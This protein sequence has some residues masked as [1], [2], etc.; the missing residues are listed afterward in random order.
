[1][2]GPWSLQPLD[3]GILYVGNIGGLN[4]GEWTISESIGA[5]VKVGEWT[6]LIPLAGKILANE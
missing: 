6:N 3:D 1:M 5:L 2:L 4:I